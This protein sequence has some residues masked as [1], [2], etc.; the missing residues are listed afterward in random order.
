MID[1]SQWSLFSAAELGFMERYLGQAIPLAATP[2]TADAL[3]DFMANFVSTAWTAMN[4]EAVRLAMQG[5][6][7][8]YFPTI[9]YDA[10]ANTFSA[11]TDQQ[12]T[13]MYEAIFSAAPSTAA[14]AMGWLQQWKPIIDIVLGDFD[15]GE[16]LDVT[17]GY[18]FASMVRAFEDVGLP[19][20]I[21]DAATAL[22]VP[23]DTIVSGTGSTLTGTA[24]PDI[25]YLS[26]GDQ[27]AEGGLGMDNYVLGAHF[28]HVTIADDEATMGAQR[29]EHP[30]LC[31]LVIDRCHGDA[32]WRGFIL[33]VNGTGQ[34]VT[35]TGEFTGV[36][37]GFFGG[38]MNDDHGV[39]QIA[40]LDGV[41]W[42]MPDIAF[43]VSHPQATNDTLVGTGAMD[44]L[45]GGA[46]NDH[47][48]G[49]DDGDIYVFGV[50]YGTDTIRDQQQWILNDALDYLEF[51]PGLTRDDITLHREADSL[52]LMISINGTNDQVTV[53]GQF[54][55]SYNIFGAMWFDRIEAFE[56]NDGSYYNWEDVIKKIVADGKTD[57]DDAIYGFSYEDTLDGGIGNDFLSGGNEN[58][59]YIFGVGYGHDV[60]HEGAINIIGGMIDKVVFNDDVLPGD[61][62]YQRDGSTNDLII[63]LASGDTLRLSEQFEAFD[64]GPFG[65]IWFDRVE[66]FE[67]SSTGD[68]VTYEDI[69]ARILVEA[70][71]AAT[72]TSTATS[73]RTRSM[74]APETTI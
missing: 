31:D 16:G 11:T 35:V 56:F 28:N 13:P 64:S 55:A 15:R 2:V 74:A 20:G 60:I 67:F 1:Q 46:G 29:P 72:T 69:M 9:V 40:F 61:V 59:T 45:D 21:A 32:R 12:L 41:V 50:G 34:Q 51:N 58:D 68:V 6:L 66:Y 44:V 25:F 43:A 4:L 49:G 33:T 39:A 19:L 65:V 36:K 54:A 8:S 3:L 24:T 5:P 47:L 48:S 38:N 42:D 23:G 17:Y 26:N 22:G 30:S 70:K 62:S 73:G 14:G 63:T 27:T 53:V 10:S 7:S 37:P 18:Q 57:G 71:T 52:D